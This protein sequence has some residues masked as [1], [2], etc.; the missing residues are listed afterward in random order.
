ML[1]RDGPL[2]APKAVGLVTVLDRSRPGMT[3]SSEKL[4]QLMAEADALE[5]AAF[6][7]ERTGMMAKEA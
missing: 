3:R 7:Q 1:F 5:E 6:Y 4:K 2:K